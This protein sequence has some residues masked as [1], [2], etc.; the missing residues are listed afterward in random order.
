M[1]QTMGLGADNGCECVG[2]QAH[3][4]TGQEHPNLTLNNLVKSVRFTGRSASS[5]SS[6]RRTPAARTSWPSRAR[7]PSTSACSG[8]RARHMG[9]GQCPV[10]KYNRQLR[11]LIAGGQGRRRRSSSATSC[12]WTRAP[13]AY[14]HFDNRDDGWT[15]V[16]LK[17]ALANA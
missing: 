1:E 15:K 7:S 13:D 9:S 10:K 17:P 8:S 4:P 5:A 6:S 11:D 12:R 2:Y 3:D 14:E 16:V